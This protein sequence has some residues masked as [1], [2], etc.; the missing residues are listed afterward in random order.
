MG[1]NAALITKKVIDNSFEVLAIQLMTV[2]QAIDYLECVPRLSKATLGVYKSVREIF[3]KF[4][5][6]TPKYK[7]L[8]RITKYLEQSEEM[9]S[10][11]EAAGR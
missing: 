10:F 9:F 6:D 5:A 8:E 2:L 1:T 11:K 3:P 7:D 4:I